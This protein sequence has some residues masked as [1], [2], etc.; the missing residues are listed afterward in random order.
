MCRWARIPRVGGEAS[1]STNDWTFEGCALRR[2]LLRGGIGLDDSA[3]RKGFVA[4]L[5]PG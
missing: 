2:L 5:W 3:M 1:G 4:F